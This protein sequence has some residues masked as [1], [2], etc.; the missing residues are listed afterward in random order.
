MSKKYRKLAEDIVSLVGGKE[1]INDVYH[2]QT[3]LRFKLK[4]ETKA[5]DEALK[6][7][8]GVASVIRNAGVYQVVIGTHVADVFEE[9]ADVADLKNKN[10]AP[11]E[12]EK[13][14]VFNTI[15]DFIAGA[16]QPIIPALSVLVWSKRYWLCWWYSMSLP[17]ILKR[18]FY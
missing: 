7:M 9:V 16:F 6:N 15:V 1:N 10:E 2:C 11:A 5:N 3:R 4:D 14:G 18:M 12:E 17:T 13:K 8:D